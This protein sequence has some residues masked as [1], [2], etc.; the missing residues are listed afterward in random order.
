MPPTSLE[1]RPTRDRPVVVVGGSASGFYAAHRLA[2]AGVPV[3]V[4]EAGEEVDPAPRTLIVTDKF[5]E[6]M[7]ELANRAIVNRIRSFE[8]I[9]DGRR[10][11]IGL[12]RPDLVIERTAVVKVLA[13][14]ARE[15]GAEIVMRRR[16]VGLEPNP[17]PAGNDAGGAIRLTFEPADRRRPPADPREVTADVVIGADGAFSTVA[18]CAGWPPQPTVPLVQA[19][20]KLPADM[21]PDATRVW[22]VPDDTPFF[23]WLIPD[24]PGR[25]GLGIIGDDRPGGKN[26][27]RALEGFLE[28][29]GLEALEVQAGKI[30]L[31]V[32]WIPV[33]RRVGR[34]DVY[35]VGD[36]AGQVKPSTVGGIVTGFRGA[37]GIVDALL[38]EGDRGP[39]D[40]PWGGGGSPGPGAGGGSG[41]R[42]GDSPGTSGLRRGAAPGAG[43]GGDGPPGHG[44]NSGRGGPDAGAT[45]GE[46]RAL[47]RELDLHMWIRRAMH[48]F[49]ARDYG[50]L[51]ALL[52][53]SARSQLG[54]FHR[55]ETWR[56]MLNLLLRQ[57]RL[58]SLGI[59][60]L[61]RR[62]SFGGR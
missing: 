20:V 44:R 33:H 52:S 38:H 43:R 7:G 2:A 13:E 42:R 4:Y 31:Y 27:G 53:D 25:G 46:I 48:D 45:N 18:R 58:L 8:L 28:R 54:R 32:E 22:F 21:P 34:G 5:R 12:D 30:P 29:L 9:A 19:I 37:Q 50:R 6:Q 3:R 15:A 59:R 41:S 55:D 24:R 57:P 40:G 39:T 16:L 60:T 11:S 47:R 35:L 26:A 1:L 62:G 61:L 23:Y 10:A 51:L 17:R 49:D 14:Q 56:L 36:A